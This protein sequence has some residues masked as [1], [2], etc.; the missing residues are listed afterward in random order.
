MPYVRES[1]R[2]VGKKTLTGGEIRRE[3]HC[4]G[5]PPRAVTNFSTALAV[6]DYPVDL[7]ACNS[8]SH[9]E[10]NLESEADVPPGFVGGPFQVPFEVF[11]PQN[12]D[13]F[14]VAEKNLS[15]SRL[16]NGA[17][18]L[19]PI[20][21]LTGQAVGAIAGLAVSKGIQ[22][23]NLNPLQVQD[24]L[25]DQGCRLALQSFA[26]VPRSNP[27]WK[28]VQLLAAHEVMQ[29]YSD[30]QF[31]IGDPLLRM[32]AAV[33]I[34]R[35][36]DISVSN[37]PPF[38]TFQDVPASHPA[39]A[40]I[41]AL[42]KEGMTS[43]CSLNPPLFC[44]EGSLTRAELATFVIRGLGLDPDNA[45]GA[46]YFNDLPGP[47][48]HWSFPFVQLIYQLGLME[49]CTPTNFCPDQPVTRGETADTAAATL[50]HLSL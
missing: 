13:G 43:G 12:V 19:Q 46:P 17:I 35:L 45:P 11:I 41:E 7:H 23:R 16:A 27:H 49:G 40:E 28:A 34:T 18:R 33:L 38:P 39:Y 24:Y 25:L 6:G 3:V 9:L 14:L 20:T 15:V 5:C 26:D 37:P 21:M 42:V 10:L 2:L 29:G 4:G 8:N 31:G 32:W 36:F 47:G 30:V 48:S 44:P 50:L 1:R 22:P